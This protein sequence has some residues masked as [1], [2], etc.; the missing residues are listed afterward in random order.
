MRAEA[1]DDRA[2]APA[3]G[4]Q[5]PE[6]PSPARACRRLVAAIAMLLAAS[7]TA[8]TAIPTQPPSVTISRLADDAAGVQSVAA[9]ELLAAYHL[10]SSDPRFGGFSAIE[11]DGRSLWLLSD[12]A[13][14]WHAAMTI[15]G[16]TGDLALESWTVG[17]ILRDAA[18]RRSLDSEALALAPDGTLMVAFEHDDSVRR[19]VPEAS[20]DW[21]TVRLH[22]GRLIGN[23]PANQGL[24]SL[25]R[26]PDGSLLA[27]SEGARVAPDIAAGAR[28]GDGGIERFGYRVAP[29]FSPVG[30]A[31]TSDHLY[32]L[33]RAVGVLTGWRSRLVRTR[34]PAPPLAGTLEGEE[35]LRINAGPLAENYEGVAILERPGEDA[36]ILLVADDNQSPLQRTLLLVFSYAG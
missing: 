11:T 16:R 34:L 20:G 18:D 3:T 35:L 22:D 5:V 21:S 9:L 24:E 36:L 28:L 2:E 13:F 23:A 19:L 12:R 7:C 32:V 31:A 29:D 10:R 27:L 33:E 6:A 15:D 1:T 26:L 17:A 30:A 4:G 25:A 8:A 14:L